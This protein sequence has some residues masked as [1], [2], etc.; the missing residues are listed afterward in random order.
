MSNITFGIIEK[1]KVYTTE[2]RLKDQAL[3]EK[4]LPNPRASLACSRSRSRPLSIRITLVTSQL[5][6][7]LKIQRSK[8]DTKRLN[9][10]SCI[11]MQYPDLMSLWVRRYICFHHVHHSIMFSGAEQ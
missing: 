4:H 10:N 5:T 3:N 7:H 6:S 11:I 9:V 1:E 2:I 8:I